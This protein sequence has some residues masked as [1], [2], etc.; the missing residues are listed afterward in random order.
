[1]DEERT[2]Q[3]MKKAKKVLTQM[4]LENEDEIELLNMQLLEDNKPIIMIEDILN[5][6]M[7]TYL[8]DRIR[9]IQDPDRRNIYL[10]EL[11]RLNEEIKQ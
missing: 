9:V 5:S 2:K 11:K 4:I 10:M 8:K 7:T 3:L 1:M 6:K